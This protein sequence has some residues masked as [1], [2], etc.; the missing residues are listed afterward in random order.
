MTQRGLLYPHCKKVILPI[1]SLFIKNLK[2]LLDI[3]GY[4]YIILFEVIM[5]MFNPVIEYTH[6]DPCTAET[7]LPSWYYIYI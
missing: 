7:L 1:L 6:S 5:C 4:T 3:I 2:I